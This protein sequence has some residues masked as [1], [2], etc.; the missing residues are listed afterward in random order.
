MSQQE[1]FDPN[2]LDFLATKK[3]PPPPPVSSNNNN[4]GDD[5]L[6]DDTDNL[7]SYHSREEDQGRYNTEGVTDRYDAFDNDGY[8][9][10]SRVKTRQGQGNLKKLGRRLSLFRS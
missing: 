3:A 8:G 6:A 4:Y 5:L 1:L 9:Q 10:F 2:Y 7:T